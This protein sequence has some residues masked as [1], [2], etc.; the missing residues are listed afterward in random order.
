MNKITLPIIC[1]ALNTCAF[2][3]ETKEQLALSY[4][5]TSGLQS[6]AKSAN[7]KEQIDQLGFPPAKNAEEKKQMQRIYDQIQSIADKSSEQK[8]KELIKIIT[9]SCTEAELQAAVRTF[10]SPEYKAISAKKPDLGSKEKQAASTLFTTEKGKSL[11]KDS[12][13]TP[14]A[15]IAAIDDFKKIPDIES[16]I[17]GNETLTLKELKFV[18]DLESSPSKEL[19]S[20]FAKKINQK[21]YQHARTPKDSDQVEMQKII[22]RELNTPPLSETSFAKQIKAAEAAQQK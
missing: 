1:I 10:T 13:D 17:E 18:Q 14:L 12:P 8:L 16:L 11:L 7:M 2:A 3:A 21:L 6:F 19:K 5:N 9:D 20:F 15:K 4:F 22:D